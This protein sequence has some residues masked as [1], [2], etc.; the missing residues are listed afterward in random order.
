[1]SGSV[2]KV[3]IIGNLGADP[4]VRTTPSGQ[5]V[6]SLSIA[7]SETF[8]DREGKRQER[9]ARVIGGP[10]DGWKSGDLVAA[11]APHVHSKR[12]IVARSRGK[13]DPTDSRH[14]AKRLA[15]LVALSV[16]GCWEWTGNIGTTG[17]GMFRVNRTS[18]AAHRV[19][20]E[21]AFGAIPD[22][23]CVLHHCDNRKCVNPAHLH[24]GDR[25]DNMREAV[26]R[27]R[28]RPPRCIIKG[29][30]NGQAKLC[31]ADVQEIRR[32]RAHGESRARLAVRFGVS[33]S[34]IIAIESGRNW[35]WLEVA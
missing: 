3:I 13:L 33:T 22:G 20:Y 32:A 16:S 6:A 35:R 1:M 10:V 17:Y 26:E 34:A 21:V 11:L 23:Q 15:L 14:I 31:E 9:T 19:S 12:S 8:N 30:Q 4:D 27:D 2:N 7:T 24:L 5:M 28:L 18:V 29:T 25:F